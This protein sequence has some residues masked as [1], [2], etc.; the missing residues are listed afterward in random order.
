MPATDR[1]SAIARQKFAVQLDQGGRALGFVVD[2]DELTNCAVD[3]PHSLKSR[4]RRRLLSARTRP[5]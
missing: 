1:H 2:E 5:C 3:R 4:R